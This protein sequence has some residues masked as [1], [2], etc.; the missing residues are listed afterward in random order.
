VLVI[1]AAFGLCAVTWRGAGVVAQGGLVL[2]V[3]GL[4]YLACGGTPT[5][6]PLV[7]VISIV[8]WLP[9]PGA[10]AWPAAL[11]L[12]VAFLG[13][14]VVTHA[15]FFGEDRY[16]LVITPVLCILAVAAFRKARGSVLS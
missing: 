5:F 15:V 11:K 6:W 4:T 9:L 8:P 10:A 12:P 1:A 7:V 13:T 3:S 16:H 2:V 14:T